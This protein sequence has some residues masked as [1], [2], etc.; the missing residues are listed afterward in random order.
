MT[1]N[2][3]LPPRSVRELVLS[4]PEPFDELVLAPYSVHEIVAPPP[5]YVHVIS[6]RSG[7]GYESGELLV[8]SHSAV[9]V[10]VVVAGHPELSGDIAP[11]DSWELTRSLA[12]AFGWRLVK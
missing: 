2:A 7:D 12:S 6:W 4:Q 5:S 10:Q 3:S 8:R 1:T 9:C 11:D